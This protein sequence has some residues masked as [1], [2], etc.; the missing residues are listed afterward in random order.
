MIPI[1]IQAQKQ[2]KIYTKVIN[3]KTKC[4]MEHKTA[5]K[6]K[7]QFTSNIKMKHKFQL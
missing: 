7:T 5:T 3:I 1:I 6:N 4:F 2:R